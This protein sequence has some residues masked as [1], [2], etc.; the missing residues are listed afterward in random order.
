M[1][2]A[3]SHAAP[4]AR[5]LTLPARSFRKQPSGLGKTMPCAPPYATARTGRRKPAA[6]TRNRTRSSGSSPCSRDRTGAVCSAVRNPGWES[7][8][9][10]NAGEQEA[11]HVALAILRPFDRVRLAKMGHREVRLER[12]QLVDIGLGFVGASKQAK[13]GDQRLI[14]GAKI[15]VGFHGAPP[16][17]HGL[18]VVALEEA[19]KHVGRFK[20]ARIWVERRQ[21]AVAF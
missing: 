14:S 8:P 13:G 16:D 7:S 5:Y 1:A 4:P 9:L 21:V 18:L 15:G 6:G 2:S 12:Q 10:G 11:A 19:R 17:K 3:S 20:K